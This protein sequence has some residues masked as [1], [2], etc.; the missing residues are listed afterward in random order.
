MSIEQMVREVL[1]AVAAED[2]LFEE[3]TQGVDPDCWS[4]SDLV[5]PANRLQECLAE[6]DE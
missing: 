3:F 4:A 6:K 1:K 5:G 2:F